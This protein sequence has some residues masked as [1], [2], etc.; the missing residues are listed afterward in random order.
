MV[1]YSCSSQHLG[2]W[3]RKME[4]HQQSLSSETPP[5]RGNGKVNTWLHL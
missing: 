3:G 5:Q 4:C 1:K 2:D